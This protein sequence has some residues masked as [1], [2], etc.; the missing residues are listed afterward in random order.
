[1]TKLNFVADNMMFRM[2]CTSQIHQE[3]AFESVLTT[4][5]PLQNSMHAPEEVDTIGL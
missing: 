1:M 2:H 3:V 5:T 4:S